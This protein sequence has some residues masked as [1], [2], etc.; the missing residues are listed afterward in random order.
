Q[1]LRR[2]IFA[3][4]FLLTI[5]VTASVILSRSIT[6]PLES[7][8]NAASAISTGD[9]SKTVK[10]Q[11]HNELVALAEAFDTMV[12]KLRQAN[13]ELEEKIQERDRTGKA[14]RESEERLQSVIENLD[15]GLVISELNGQLISWNRA[16]LDMHGFQSM[17]ECLLRLPE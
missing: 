4:L 10:V 11:S 6:R 8:T 12:G 16:A 9:Y 7:L 17:D 5:G 3:S 13:L 1:F 14:L 15:E 2:M